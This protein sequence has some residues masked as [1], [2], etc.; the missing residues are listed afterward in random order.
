MTQM[1]MEA[2]SPKT[3]KAFSITGNN[4]GHLKN[5]C[6]GRNQLGGK[7][8][9]LAREIG[10]RKVLVLFRVTSHLDHN[11]S[12]TRTH[13]FNFYIFIYAAIYGRECNNKSQHHKIDTN[14]FKILVICF[15][16]KYGRRGFYCHSKL[17]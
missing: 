16:Y 14:L 5:M 12:S 9:V 8:Q 4:G 15:I 11:S 17:H 10:E 1:I 3:R 13:F 6:P 2:G 7:N